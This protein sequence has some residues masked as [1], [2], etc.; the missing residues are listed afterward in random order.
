LAEGIAP[1]RHL[2]DRQAEQEVTVGGPLGGEDP[3][4]RQRVQPELGHV[5]GG[6]ARAGALKQA[7]GQHRVVEVVVLWHA[8]DVLGQ[9]GRPGAAVPGP[10]LGHGGGQAQLGEIAVERPPPSGPGDRLDARTGDLLHRFAQQATG[11]PAVPGPGDP[12]GQRG[13]S[14]PG[15]RRHRRHQF[16][17]LVPLVR[18]G[19]VGWGRAGVDLVDQL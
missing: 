2:V 11:R 7:Q 18:L 1:N 4:G 8:V 13:R 15:R 17:Q 12:L 3:A 14:G 10:A 5:R 9:A 6:E 19:R 16:D